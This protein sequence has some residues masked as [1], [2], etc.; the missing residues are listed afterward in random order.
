V[1]ESAAPL[2]FAP[3]HARFLGLL[4]R[5][6]QHGRIFFRFLK[7][8][9]RQAEALAEMRALVWRWSLR[10]A[11]QGRDASAFG[12]ALATFAAR[13]V[14]SGRRLCGQE[15]ARDVLSPR[16]QQRHGFAVEELPASTASAH[17]TLHGTVLGQR[18]QDVFE[19]RLRDNTV[20]PVPDQVCFRID[21]PAWLATLTA[22]ERRIIRAMARNERTSDLSRQFEVSPSRISQL[23]AEFHADWERFCADPGADMPDGVV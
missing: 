20:T 11:Q 10:L 15:K 21:F 1:S 19:E 16:A 14:H 3:L 22:R 17:E 5:I 9:H 7:C 8:P 4:P 18:Q 12:T 23:R 6:E 13:A 2:P